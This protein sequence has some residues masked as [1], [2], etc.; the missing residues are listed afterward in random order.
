MDDEDDVFDSVDVLYINFTQKFRA[1]RIIDNECFI[2]NWTL[3]ANVFNMD[4]ANNSALN[5]STVKIKF[6]FENIVEDSL[7]FARTN[8]WAAKAFLGEDG[9]PSTSTNIILTPEDPTDD[10]LALILQNKMN[11]LASENVMFNSIELESDNARGLS[12]LYVGETETHLPGPE[13]WIEPNALIDPW[14][15]RDDASTFDSTTDEPKYANSLDFLKEVIMTPIPI[16]THNSE[17]IRPDFN[18]RV[19]KGT[20]KDD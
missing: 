6:W 17:L 12:F 3:K 11:S 10:K 15:A 20:K 19:I 4:D 18:L 1:I 13:D 14:W 8:E 5:L 16:P 7:I 9:L 2:T